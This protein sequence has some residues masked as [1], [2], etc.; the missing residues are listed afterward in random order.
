[1]IKENNANGSSKPSCNKNTV[2][3]PRYER[4]NTVVA[5]RDSVLK[6][7][8][9][10][11]GG[12]PIYTHPYVPDIIVVEPTAKNRELLQDLVNSHKII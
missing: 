12:T 9:D 11:L 5:D 10:R 7:I 3:I 8:K 6:E 2:I 1:V 4:I